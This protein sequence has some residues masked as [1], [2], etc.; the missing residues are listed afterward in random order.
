MNKQSNI[1]R[2]TLNF[3]LSNVSLNS[4]LVRIVDC[5]W[6]EEHDASLIFLIFCPMR[7]ICISDMRQTHWVFAKEGIRGSRS[8]NSSKIC[9]LS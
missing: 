4:R 1:G 3:H 5:L 6:C 7:S 9:F 2:T 8:G